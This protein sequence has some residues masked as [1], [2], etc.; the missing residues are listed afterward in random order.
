MRKKK[1]KEKEK[2]AAQSPAAADAAEQSPVS[3]RVEYVRPYLD[4]SAFLP[5]ETTTPFDHSSPGTYQH[6]CTRARTHSG[7]TRP[8][9]R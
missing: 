8:V 4:F 1:D 3:E 9:C 2:S 5:A 6:L 7:L